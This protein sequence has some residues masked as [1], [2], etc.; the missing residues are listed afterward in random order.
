M[1]LFLCIVFILQLALSSQ[2]PVTSGVTSSKECPTCSRGPRPPRQRSSDGGGGMALA[3]GEACG[4]YTLSSCARGLRCM[5][6]E[7]E[8]RPLQALLDGRGVCSESNP[9]AKIHSVGN[10][11]TLNAEPRGTALW[12]IMLPLEGDIR[13][14]G[15]AA[16]NNSWRTCFDLN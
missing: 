9:T 15:R 3:M 2:G 8:A 5:P 14:V 13:C 10:V 7:D 11:P 12:A 4:V 1:P 6:P 16:N